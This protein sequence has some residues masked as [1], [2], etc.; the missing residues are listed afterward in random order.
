MNILHILSSFKIGGAERFVS[1]LALEQSRQGASVLI[2]GTSREAGQLT[3]DLEHLG[4]AWEILSKS[5]FASY[6]LVLRQLRASNVQGVLH[7]HSPAALRYF[8][9]ILPIVKLLGGCVIYTRHG[10]APLERA[11]WGRIHAVARPF[12]NGVTFVSEEGRRVFAE[13]FGWSSAKL[14]MI[15]NGVSIPSSS[16]PIAR[17]DRLKLVSVGRM[18]ALKGQ[19]FLLQAIASLDEAKRKD[20]DLHFFGDGPEK[21]NLEA[22][23]E[24]LNITGQC[25][26]HGMQLDR[27]VIYND[28]DLQVVCSE[29]EGLSI[30]IMESM[31]RGIPAVATNVG[32]NAKLV[33]HD[34]TGMLYEFSDV[35]ALATI[36][37]E[38]AENRG[39]LEDHGNAAR[40]HIVENFSIVNTVENYRSKYLCL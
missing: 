36:L 32:D 7:I 29:Q 15:P 11:H 19:R 21:K 1:E 5:R 3:E 22:L 18:V 20:F 40:E 9:P 37:V 14:H 33:L 35:E 17:R 27:D 2:V 34:K 10:I 31:A 4:V 24:S 16:Q 39:T 23:A 28:V 6:M 12:I 25:A 8:L 13:R 38:L 26:F 30:A